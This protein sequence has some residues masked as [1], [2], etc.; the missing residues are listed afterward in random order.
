MPGLIRPS[1]RIVSLAC[2]HRIDLLLPHE[3]LGF[4]A[5]ALLRTLDFL[6]HKP[7]ADRGTRIKEFC[8]DLG[9]VY[10]KIGQ[11]LSTRRDLIDNELA[12][13]LAEL[14]DRVPPIENLDIKVYV[15]EALQQPW[16]NAFASIDDHPLA[17]ASIAQVHKGEL[18][19]GE[20]IVVKVVR[21]DIEARINEDMQH[22]VRLAEWIDAKFSSTRRF[23]LPNLM[24]DHYAILVSELDMLKEAANQTQLR[25]NFAE[26]DLLY[27]PRTYPEW[28]RQSLLT[29]EYVEGIPIN[30][31]DQLV[32]ANVDLEVLAHKGV[33]TFFTQVFEQNF[34]H[35]DM[36]PGNILIDVRDPTNPR[37]IALDCAIIGNLPERDQRYLALSLV[38]FFKR[39]YETVAKLFREC[40]WVPRS[41][42]LVKFETVIREIC[43]PIFAKPLAEISF[44]EFVIDLF[45]AAGKFDMEMQPQLAL[46]Q[47][48]LLYVEGLGR[49]LYPQ[50]DLW[51]TAQ[52]FMQRWVAERLNPI[53]S[54][55]DWI[56][57][58]PE[59]WR[60][61][62][63]LPE[64]IADMQT[65]LQTLQGQLDHL[66]AIQNTTHRQRLSQQRIR[67][68][69]GTALI[70]GSVALLW[71][72]LLDGIGGGDISMLAGI[73]GALLGSTLLIRA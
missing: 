67:R 2:K 7:Q 24:R 63:R 66:T 5:R 55:I 40:G 53:S 20:T 61:L 8:L 47:K 23:H 19:T 60:P 44:A 59:A 10:I 73:V 69:S 37:Y 48:T 11:L 49:Q 65:N 68:W 13:A 1:L 16:Q 71:R 58:G 22:I 54:L 38:A 50:L 12:D 32:A 45:R 43:D 28:C 72:P 14:Q 9:P 26:S 41:T 3:P 25:R 34:F 31:I 62:I 56:N 29:M 39:D 4:V 57:A 46:L 70:V 42:D 35:A 18:T 51:A 36:H 30:H 6:L 15:T 27:V 21:P 52:P 33:E 64:T 17:S